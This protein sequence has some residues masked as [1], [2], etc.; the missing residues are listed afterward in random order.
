MVLGMFLQEAG[1][2][3]MSPS[4]SVASSA[5]QTNSLAMLLRLRVRALL[6][7]THTHTHTHTRGWFQPSPC[8]CTGVLGPTGSWSFVA[9]CPLPSP[10]CP[11]THAHTHGDGSHHPRVCV[12]GSRDA[13]GRSRSWVGCGMG[14]WISLPIRPVAEASPYWLV[15]FDVELQPFQKVFEQGQNGPRLS[16]LGS[17]NP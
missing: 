9:G 8:M 7:H 12:L 6:S 15:T 16:F 1:R 2:V 14:S 13:V 4:K 17:S 3:D 10:P 11:H 5:L